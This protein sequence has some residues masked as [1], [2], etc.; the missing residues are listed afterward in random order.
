MEDIHFHC[1]QKKYGVQTYKDLLRL[2]YASPKTSTGS[3]RKAILNDLISQERFRDYLHCLGKVAAKCEET[4]IYKKWRTGVDKNAVIYAN[5]V[6]LEIASTG[7]V[8]GKFS[9]TYGMA[10]S[11]WK[12]IT[13]KP[14]WET[15]TT[16][17][18]VYDRPLIQEKTIKN[19]V[20]NPSTGE[21]ES[22]IVGTEYYVYSPDGTTQVL[23]NA[24]TTE[25]GAIQAA[26]NA[27]LFHRWLNHVREIPGNPVQVGTEY[28]WGS[29][30]SIQFAKEVAP[31]YVGG[32]AIGSG[33]DNGVKNRKKK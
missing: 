4:G 13:K 14:L 8:S 25:A 24:F 20:F 29:D 10:E 1:F 33:I 16:R 9:I 28:G 3:K 27:G 30:A 21:M 7:K 18:S 22:V 15:T 31:G 11:L 6:P 5:G 12:Q 2:Y 26:K 19:D 32:M 23:G 17:E